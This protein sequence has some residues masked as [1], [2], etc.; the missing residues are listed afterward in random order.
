MSSYLLYATGAVLIF[1][2]LT[3][4]SVGNIFMAFTVLVLGFLAV[5]QGVKIKKERKLKDSD[6]FIDPETGQLYVKKDSEE[7]SSN[8]SKNHTKQNASE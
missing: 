3:L 2:G 7:E 6:S 5:N 4:F 1:F 8:S